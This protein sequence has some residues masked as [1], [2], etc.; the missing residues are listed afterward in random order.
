GA[1]TPE[2]LLSQSG[3]AAALYSQVKY[4]EAKQ[5][6][7]RAIQANE[8]VLS[9]EH[10]ETLPST[11]KLAPLIRSEGDYKA[12]EAIYRSNLASYEL[13][14]G[15]LNPNTVMAMSRLRFVLNMNKNYGEAE[16]LNYRAL[17]LA[18]IEFG[19]SH[20]RTLASMDNSG[21]S[22]MGYGQLKDAQ[23]VF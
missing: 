5:I 13:V 23:A 4:E 3:L 22:L 18:I 9:S 12:A 10:P 16:E 14:L 7:D 6:Y 15:E 21:L 17:V 1:E 11:I 8:K 19:G 2:I 20:H